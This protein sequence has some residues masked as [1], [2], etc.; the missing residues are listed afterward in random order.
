MSLLWIINHL[1]GLVHLECGSEKYANKKQ[2]TVKN[3]IKW[4]NTNSY[5]FRLENALLH[6]STSEEDATITAH[7]KQNSSRYE[8][9]SEMVIN[10]ISTVMKFL[11]RIMS[12]NPSEKVL[13]RFPFFVGDYE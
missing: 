2:N 4:E 12:H 6:T 13:L 10:E 3:R 9:Y 5:G 8:S 11:F 7:Y 1:K